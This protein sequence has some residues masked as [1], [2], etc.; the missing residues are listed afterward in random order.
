MECY[1]R[2]KHFDYFRGLAYPYMG[3]TVNMDIT[4]LVAEIKAKKRPFFL[5]IC[6]AVAGAANGVPEFRQRIVGDGIA[7][8]EHCK[9]SHTVALEDGTYCYCTLDSDM[10]LAKFIPYAVRAQERAKHVKNTEDNPDEVSGLIFISTLPWMSYT[11]IIQPVPIPADSNPRITWGRYFEQDG[12]VLIPIS[13]L[14]NHALVDGLHIA[15]FYELLGRQAEKLAEMI[16]RDF[17]DAM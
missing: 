3:A 6:Y 4:K 15:R 2:K 10:P 16:Q 7:E 14:C 9:T 17:S 13:V 12:K 5:T 11:A 8:Y 1:S